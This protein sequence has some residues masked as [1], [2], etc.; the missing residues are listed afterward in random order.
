MVSAEKLLGIASQPLT[1]AWSF[2]H[3][4]RRRFS[5]I[6]FSG[7][8]VSQRTMQ[9]RLGSNVQPGIRYCIAIASSRAPRPCCR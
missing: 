3:S 1:A 9:G 4:V 7:S 2:F 8:G 6:G 5:L